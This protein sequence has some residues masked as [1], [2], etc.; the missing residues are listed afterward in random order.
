MKSAL[1]RLFVA[2]L[3]AFASLAGQALLGQTTLSSANADELLAG[4]APTLNLNG[5]YG[6]NGFTVAVTNYDSAATYTFSATQGTLTSVVRTTGGGQR[7]LTINVQS[8]PIDDSATLTVTA[9]KSGY[10]SESS[11]IVGYAKKSALV[12]VFGT[13]EPTFD[14]FTVT[15]LNYT[16][17]FTW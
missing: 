5:F 7:I 11:S 1:N 8:I 14:G 12:P 6:N 4:V 15:V 3:I 2:L 17:G 9:A 16:A 13:P 10:T